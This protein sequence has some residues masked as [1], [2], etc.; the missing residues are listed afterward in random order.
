MCALFLFLLTM[1]ME[2]NNGIIKIYR[3]YFCEEVEEYNMT[4][5]TKEGKK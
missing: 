2:L 4:N 3:L 1:K 5:K